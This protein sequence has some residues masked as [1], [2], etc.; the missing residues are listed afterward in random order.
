MDAEFMQNSGCN[1]TI[2][3][4]RVVFSQ[5]LYCEEIDIY[6]FCYSYPEKLEHTEEWFLRTSFSLTNADHA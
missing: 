6:D 5:V 4:S 1:R 3:K 2:H